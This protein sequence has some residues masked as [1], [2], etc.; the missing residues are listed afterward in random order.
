[1]SY[2]EI[3]SDLRAKLGDSPE[4]NDKLLREAGEKFAKEGNAEGFEAVNT[5]V[6]E[7]MPEEKRKE[8][9]RLT[10]VDGVRLDKLHE[11][12][13]KLISQRKFVEAKSLAERLYKKITVEYK[14]TDKEKFVSLRNPFED[15]LY[16]LMYKP[17]KTLNRCPYDFAEYI[18][19]YAFLIVETGSPLDAIPVLEKA[20]EYNPVDCGPKFELAE[21]YKL[22]KNRKRLLDLTKE[23][24]KV[25]SSPVAI[26]R[27][28]ANMGYILTDFQEYEDAAA[29]YTA[30]VMMSPN[31]AIPREMQHLADLMGKP[32]TH[33]GNEKI[34]EVMKKYD[35][36]FGPDQDVVSVAAQLASY[37]LDKN[38]IPN[39][40][41]AMK[42]TYNLTLDERV[43]DL[44]IKYD[45]NAIRYVPKGTKAAEEAERS[46]ITRTVNEDPEK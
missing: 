45:P 46:G 1:M 37:Y 26:A 17:E 33:P 40:L 22:L 7:N 39:A 14:E 35:M 2:D 4:E 16:Q 41:N 25:A 44:I 21:V 8:Y 3:L 31:P 15:E 18:T 11:N 34:I 43:K 28:Y 20:M 38:D 27:C 42:M 23:T 32:L 29:F 24:L 19:T 9:E 30:S 12:I 13:E 10:H 36:E 5:L 6:L